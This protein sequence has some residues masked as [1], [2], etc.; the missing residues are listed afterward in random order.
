[1]NHP[2]IRTALSVTLSLV[3]AASAVAGSLDDAFT[4]VQHGD[5]LTALR[6]YRQAADQGSANA[7]YNLGVMCDRAEGMPKDLEQ[8]A[9]WYRKAADQGDPEAQFNLGVMY[10][11]GDGVSKN[12][13]QAVI[14]YRKAADQGLAYAQANLA[15][16]YG[17]GHGVPKSYVQAYM[18]LTLAISQSNVRVSA[19]RDRISS[20]MTPS[21]IARAQK[22]AIEWMTAFHRRQTCPLETTGH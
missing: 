13:E 8:A 19:D 21:Q 12:Y 17:K 5:Y 6:L 18:W 4:A 2:L 10:E 16:M 3:L 9:R 7:Q 14:W 1:M 22:L 11:R 20:H 15:G